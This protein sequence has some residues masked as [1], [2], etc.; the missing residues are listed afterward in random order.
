[1]KKN[2][3]GFDR[4][5]RVLAALIIAGL[6]FAH[7]ISGTLAIVLLAVAAIFIVTSFVAVCPLYSILGISSRKG[8]EKKVTQA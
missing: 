3:S 5:I 8:E 6:Y 2:M 1:M 4:T 7:V